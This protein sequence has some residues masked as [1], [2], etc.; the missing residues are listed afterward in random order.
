MVLMGFLKNL[1]MEH[2]YGRAFIKCY[3]AVSP[4]VVRLFGD[5]QV[6]KNYFKKR[7]D[8]CVSK[9]NDHGYGDKPYYDR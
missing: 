8:K 1:N 6:F 7:L 4:T 3:Y 5:T 9:L 2:R